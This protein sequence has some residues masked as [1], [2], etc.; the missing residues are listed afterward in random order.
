MRP[1]IGFGF[2]SQLVEKVAPILSTKQTD[3]RQKQS[4]RELFST[5]N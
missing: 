1:V 5:L 3:I 2:A 4:K